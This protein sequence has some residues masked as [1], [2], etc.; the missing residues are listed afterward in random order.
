MKSIIY[1]PAA[2]KALMRMPRQ[3]AKRIIVKIEQYASDPLSLTN[4]VKA[5]QG[6]DG[7]RLRVGNWRVIMEDGVVLDVLAIGNRSEIYR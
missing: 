7:I 1:Q 3:D 4:N 6:R 5:L 2:R